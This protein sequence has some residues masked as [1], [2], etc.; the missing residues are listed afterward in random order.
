MASFILRGSSWELWSCDVRCLCRTLKTIDGFLKISFS[1]TRCSCPTV[2]PDSNVS[3]RC[4]E[5]LLVRHKS[6]ET[7]HFPVQT[8]GH[9]PSKR[10]KSSGLVWRPHVS[11]SFQL[12][13]AGGAHNQPTFGFFLFPFPQWRRF[14]LCWSGALCPAGTSCLWT[15][16]CQVC[17]LVF[18]LL[19]AV[20]LAGRGQIGSTFL[21]LN[22]HVTHKLDVLF[23][24]TVFREKQRANSRHDERVAVRMWATELQV[25]GP[26]EPDDSFSSRELWTTSLL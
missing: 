9:D 16:R 2:G 7:R 18:S 23:T 22:P 14:C 21:V 4:L 19:Q 1:H 8:W 25:K 11:V 3:N 15:Q 10:Q 20:V 5:L 13:L 26:A 17:F 12:K 24:P 6:D